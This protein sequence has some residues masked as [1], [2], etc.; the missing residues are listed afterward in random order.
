MNYSDLK[1]FF[2]SEIDVSGLKSM[3]KEEVQEYKHGLLNK[4]YAPVIINYVPGEYMDIGMFHFRKICN[5]Y[6][7][8]LITYYEMFYIVDAIQMCD[9]FRFETE[10]IADLFSSI[11]DPEINGKINKEYVYSLLD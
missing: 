9:H 2:D 10:E 8:G 1:R 11:T 7:D 3:I 6:L 4:K 5:L